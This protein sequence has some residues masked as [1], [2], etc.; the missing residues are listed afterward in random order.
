[1]KFMVVFSFENC[2][3]HGERG[4]LELFDIYIPG[5]CGNEIYAHKVRLLF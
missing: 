2:F 4:D 1:M 5:L 3:Y